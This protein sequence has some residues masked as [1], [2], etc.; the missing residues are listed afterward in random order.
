MLR[1]IA[2]VISLVVMVNFCESDIAISSTGSLS[3]PDSVT[4]V[5]STGGYRFLKF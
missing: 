4:A 1:K 3:R 2:T 5:A